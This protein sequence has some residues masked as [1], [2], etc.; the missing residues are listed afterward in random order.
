[1]QLTETPA[2]QRVADRI[3]AEV[4][5]ELARQGISQ[6]VL[7]DRLG[8]TQMRVSRR[9]TTTVPFTVI[10]LVAIA[11]ALGVPLAQFL[12]AEMATV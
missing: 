2:G 11:A 6:Q 8:W 12:P 5:A 3:A 9:I 1:M 7:A 4:R 10:E